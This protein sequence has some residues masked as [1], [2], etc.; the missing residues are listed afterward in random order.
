MLRRLNIA[1]AILS[2]VI[3]ITLC[4]TWARLLPIR[5][6]IPL[7]G[8]F[9]DWRLMS[10]NGRIGFDDRPGRNRIIDAWRQEG[11]ERIAEWRRKISRTVELYS[12]W[13]ASRSPE[14]LSAYDAAEAAQKDMSDV[15]TAFADR[16]PRW[17]P[18]ATHTLPIYPLIIATSLWPG[19]MFFLFV[20]RRMMLRR[21]RRAGCCLHCGY[22]LRATPAGDSFLSRCPECG[23]VSA[24]S[25]AGL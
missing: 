21:R 20:R 11:S 8:P 10:L 7:R 14:A 24:G 12:A 6:G 13:E 23:R 4:A 25:V 3:C 19:G 1:G 18:L 5:D 17:K 9:A 22:D 15:I 16:D 2:A